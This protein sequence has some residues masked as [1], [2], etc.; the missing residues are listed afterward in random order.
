MGRYLH[1]FQKHI[2]EMMVERIMYE[3]LFIEKLQRQTSDVYANLTSWKTSFNPLNAMTN[4]TIFA[5][6]TS[7]SYTDN[8]YDR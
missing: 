7:I 8:K 2:N 5:A 4:D 3:S 6:A 1:E